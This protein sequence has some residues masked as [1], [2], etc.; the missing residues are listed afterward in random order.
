MIVTPNLAAAPA[1][2][3]GPA[4][5]RLSVAAEME[6]VFAP[7]PR[8]AR[9]A[10]DA[11]P[12]KSVAARRSNRRR[13]GALFVAAMLIAAMVLIFLVRSGQ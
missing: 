12:A 6:A 5:S 4:E 8:P 10:P 7:L 9:A 3:G 1:T 2:A 13:W 11:P